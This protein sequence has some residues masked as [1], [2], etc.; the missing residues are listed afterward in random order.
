MEGWISLHRQIMENEL[1]LSERFTKVQAWIDLLMLANHKSNTV[2]IRGN[3]V[4]TERGQLCWSI[5][6]LAKRWKWDRKTV[7][8][9]LQY[10]E[11][12]E[13]IHNRKTHITTIITIVKYNCYQLNGQQNGQQ[14]DN[15]RDTNNNDNN[16]NN[17]LYEQLVKFLNEEKIEFDEK[18]LKGRLKKLQQ[19]YLQEDIVNSIN[20]AVKN[21]KEKNMIGD[22]ISYFVTI[23]KNNY[24][25]LDAGNDNR[26]N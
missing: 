17:L 13:M 25:R 1:W 3:E 5:L 23:L 4:K 9:F 12:R 14:K 10:L 6:S 24:L 26:S 22:F 18:I 16:E 8:K 21:W 7:N 2:F 19:E 20:E 15:R 11:K